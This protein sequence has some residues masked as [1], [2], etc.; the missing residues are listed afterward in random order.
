VH[1]VNG[2]SSRLTPVRVCVCVCVLQ[3][4][5]DLV[6][7]LASVVVRLVFLPLEEGFALYFARWA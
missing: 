1:V 4:M 3:S 5:F 7:N 6:H 2:E